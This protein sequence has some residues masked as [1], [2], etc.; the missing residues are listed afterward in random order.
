M[1]AESVTP[2]NGSC[3]IVFFEHADRQGRS[4]PL[5]GTLRSL[6]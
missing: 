1:F 4:A 2:A 5:A 3:T 6:S